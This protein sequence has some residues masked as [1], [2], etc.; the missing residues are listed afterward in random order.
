MYHKRFC[1]AARQKVANLLLLRKAPC[2]SDSL[3]NGSVLNDNLYQKVG[4]W[5]S[6][7]LVRAFLVQFVVFL[8]S[9]FRSPLS[10]LLHASMVSLWCSF[11]LVFF[12]YFSFI[13]YLRKAVLRGCGISCEPLLIC[14]FSERCGKQSN[15]KIVSVSLLFAKWFSFLFAK[16]STSQSIINTLDLCLA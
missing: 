16:T 13:W 1:I 11:W 12:S 15:F 5:Q 14:F 7:S 8:C 10:P 2:K 6:M 4:V 9:C 3:N